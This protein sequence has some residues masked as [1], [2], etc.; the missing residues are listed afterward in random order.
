VDDNILTSNSSEFLNR[1]IADL[2]FKFA[3]T[4]LGPLQHFLGISVQHHKGGL[5]LSQQQYAYDLL[6]HAQMTNYN[7]CL[8]LSILVPNHPPPMASL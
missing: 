6:D 1:I 5:I 7:P 4:D 8:T 3:M 2:C